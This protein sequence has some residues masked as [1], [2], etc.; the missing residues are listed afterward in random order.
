MLQVERG[1]LEKLDWKRQ[2]QNL[3]ISKLNLGGVFSVIEVADNEK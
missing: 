3:T 2:K 1:L